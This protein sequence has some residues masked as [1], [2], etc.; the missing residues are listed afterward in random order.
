MD[1]S[2]K[3]VLE[4]AGPERRWPLWVRGSLAGG[5][6]AG[7]MVILLLQWAWSLSMWP[8]GGYHTDSYGGFLTY[9]TV[10]HDAPVTY[11]FHWWAFGIAL[12]GSFLIVGV[13]MR[14]VWRLLRRQVG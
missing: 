10:V 14:Y 7:V 2:E 8:I 11:T 6:I 1:D 4:Y 12:A 9:L 3:R 5:V 13:A